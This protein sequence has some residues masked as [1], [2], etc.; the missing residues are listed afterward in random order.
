MIKIKYKKNFFC[1]F[2]FMKFL[3]LM[4]LNRNK[5]D[6]VNINEIFVEKKISKTFIKDN[7]RRRDNIELPK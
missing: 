7:E 3:I 2:I 5:N 1:L 6:K 4:K